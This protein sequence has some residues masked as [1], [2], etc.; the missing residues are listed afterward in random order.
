[1]VL[2]HEAHRRITLECRGRGGLEPGKTAKFTVLTFADDVPAA[3]A[4]RG[5]TRAAVGGISMGAA[6]AL[7]RALRRPELVQAMILVRPE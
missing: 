4:A 5:V 1:M 2:P 6:I 7:Q 3:A